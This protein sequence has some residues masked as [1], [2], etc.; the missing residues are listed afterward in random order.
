LKIAIPLSLIVAVSLAQ[1]SSGIYKWVD[2]DG[3]LHFSECPPEPEEKCEVEEVMVTPGPALSEE[4]LQRIAK[5]R[6]EWMQELHEKSQARQQQ[7]KE[8][9]ASRPQDVEFSKQQCNLARD[10]LDQLLRA[11]PVYRYRLERA[12]R[13]EQQEEDETLK[14]IA[15]MLEIIDQDCE[16]R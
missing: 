15:T 11:E 9:R 8:K 14:D 7:Q 12:R 5:R 4:E 6:V 13:V 1:A 2:A 3:N 10:N 16:D